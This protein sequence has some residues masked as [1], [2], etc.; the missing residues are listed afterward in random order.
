MNRTL[1]IVFGIL[2]IGGGLLVAAL[3]SS[4]GKAAAAASFV[5]CPA[6]LVAPYGGTDGWSTINVQANFARALMAP[7]NKMTC[8]YR[9]GS[10]SV[11]F[12][13]QKPCPVGSLCVAVRNGFRITP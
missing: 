9:F 1:T 3:G 4:R 8:Q 7:G 2:L 13:I 6:H 5:P 11:F 10:G 12:G